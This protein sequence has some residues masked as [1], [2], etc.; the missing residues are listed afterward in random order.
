MCAPAIIRHGLEKAMR[1]ARLATWAIALG[2]LGN[3][4]C[5]LVA[6]ATHTF[7]SRVHEAFDEVREKKRNAAWAEQAWANA[8][9]A[10]HGQPFSEDHEFGFKAGFICYV[11]YGGNGEPPP[12]PPEKYRSV[13]Y[14]TPQGYRAIEEWFEGYRHGVAVVKEGGYR[15]LVTGPS[16]LHAKAF[17]PAPV[18]TAP[19]PAPLP[20]P[21]IPLPSSPAP[22]PPPVPVGPPPLAAPTTVSAP[23]PARIIPAEPPAPLSPL[24]SSDLPPPKSV[25]PAGATP[26]PEI[27]PVAAGSSNSFFKPW[28]RFRLV[29]NPDPWNLWT[30]SP[31][32]R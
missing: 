10:A 25:P 17:P 26:A 18:P 13:H 31:P 19:P 4:G 7:S 3:A 22:L 21:P 14:Q 8:A 28:V 11:T 9:G 20:S 32:A 23:P 27:R 6:N 15:D 1:R 24:A 30:K 2:V 16:S 12:L 29:I 5:G